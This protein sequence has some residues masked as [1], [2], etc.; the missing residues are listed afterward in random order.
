MK[1]DV[2]YTDPTARAGRSLLDKLSD[3][4]DRAGGPAIFQKG[5][6]VGIK[7]HFGEEG[8]TSYLNPS[9]ARLL[10][11]KLTE[12][13]AKPFLF[14]TNTLYRAE[15]HESAAHLAVARRHGFTEEN[16]GAP[17]VIADEYEEI[18]GKGSDSV[19]V[20][21]ARAVREADA[22]LVITHATG[23]ILFGYA[24]AI[25]NVSMGF[26]SPV[27]KQIIHS[28]LKPEVNQKKCVGCGTCVQYCPAGAIVLIPANGSGRARSASM[29]VEQARPLQG[30]E[31]SNLRARID[32]KK[33]VG[34]GECI[35]VCP[36][37]A[38]PPLWKGEP[39]R[40][41]EKSAAY[42]RAALSGK[43]GKV[44]FF[45][46]L[47][48][49][50]PDCDCCDWSEPPFVPD[51][52]ILASGDILAADQASVDLIQKAPLLPGCSA[53]K[54]KVKIS[55]RVPPG[56]NSQYNCLPR[57]RD[58]FKT[59]FGVDIEFF[60]AAAEKGGLGSRAYRLKKIS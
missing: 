57:L 21:I 37:G 55:R 26:T 33:C 60:L 11:K 32:K 54:K 50:A 9:F 43:E 4:F 59:L 5:D 8:N 34:C 51:L 45:N 28:D 48:T 6:T 25:K 31:K 1:S 56:I 41:A 29:E 3:L 19:R 22:I 17:I 23:H 36:A 38:I 16:I 13:G 40:I 44:L 27:G 12:A 42:A 35:T 39:G 49:V 2:Y 14:D 10:V 20:M 24:G 18:D 30:G 7:V 15:R 53:V 58:K 46:F 47:I 52:G